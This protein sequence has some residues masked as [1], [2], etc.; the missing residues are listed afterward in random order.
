[1]QIEIEIQE[2]AVI[3]TDM[4]SKKKSLSISKRIYLVQTYLVQT[5][6][7]ITLSQLKKNHVNVLVFTKEAHQVYFPVVIYM[8]RAVRGS[9]KIFVFIEHNV[10][11]TCF[12]TS[13]KVIT[14]TCNAG[15]EHP[16]DFRR[17]TW[18]T[19]QIQVG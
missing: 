2:Q 1:M 10:R 6:R 9:F 5:T 12:D 16:P 8:G 13:I 15:S 14:V 17:M 18:G 11:C 19:C 4:N 7:K 3:M